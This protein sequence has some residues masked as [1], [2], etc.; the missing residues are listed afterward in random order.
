MFKV[1]VVTNFDLILK[2]TWPEK[3]SQML[4]LSNH[5][6]SLILSALER[7]GKCIPHCSHLCCKNYKLTPVHVLLNN[8][9][10]RLHCVLLFYYDL[11]VYFFSKEKKHEVIFKEIIILQ[12]IEIG[13][14]F[15]LQNELTISINGK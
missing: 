15:F 5:I 11:G 8:S 1:H 7:K 9:N 12:L 6:F 3:L 2:L 10:A 13:I 4:D 14:V